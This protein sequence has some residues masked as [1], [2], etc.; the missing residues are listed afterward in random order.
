MGDIVVVER[1][2]RDQRRRVPE[3][4]ET[5][6]DEHAIASTPRSHVE[7]RAHRRE[8]VAP[9]RPR[10]GLVGGGQEAARCAIDLAVLAEVEDDLEREVVGDGGTPIAVADALEVAL[11]GRAAVALG[12]ARAEHRQV[13]G[14]VRERGD[15]AAAVAGLVAVPREDSRGILGIQQARV[16]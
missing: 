3:L 16:R 1:E 14:L 12:G 15:V 6:E 8:G 5:M 13:V 11:R 4:G 9:Q 10:A 7:A 2:R